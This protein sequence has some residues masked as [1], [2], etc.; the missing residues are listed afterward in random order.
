[1]SESISYRSTSIFKTAFINHYIGLYKKM[2]NSFL[3]Y[4]GSKLAGRANLSECKNASE[5]C[6]FYWIYHTITKVFFSLWIL[7]TCFFKPIERAT[8]R[9]FRMLWKVVVESSFENGSSSIIEG[10]M[11][12]FVKKGAFSIILVGMATIIH[13]GRYW[14]QSKRLTG[15]QS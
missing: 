12:D 2:Y 1:M 3:V 4:L 6:P 13:L 14:K 9:R 7:M 15:N 10:F 8:R 5:K 11:W